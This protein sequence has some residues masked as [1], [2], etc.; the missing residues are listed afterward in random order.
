LSPV[1]FTLVL[2]SALLH[3][4]WSVSIKGSRDPL[5]FNA[6]QEV[7]AIAL[8]LATLPLLSL[9][10]IPGSVWKLLALTGVA[11]ALYFYWMSRAYEHGDLTLVYPIARSTPAFLPLVAVPLF[12]EP[13]SPGGALGI[14]VVVAGMWLVHAGPGLRWRAF[15]SPGAA[16]AYL[17]LAA[18][19]V[20]SLADKG[21]MAELARAPWSSPVPRAAAFYLL[22]SGASALLFIPIVLHRRGLR[23][24]RVAARSDLGSATRASLVSFLGYGLI[25]KALE[26]APASYVV[27]VRQTS[28]I[29]ALLL[30]AALLRERPTRSRIAGASATVLG[31]AL[32]A[33]CGT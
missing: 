20:Y 7:A 31:V 32:I 14:A 13:V 10:E 5:V 2:A 19:V 1:E 12:G 18:T 17:T 3:A 16:Y 33:H 30:G 4:W 11:H 23:C 8:L 21:A 27:A 22:L 25:L 29:F 15:A 26:T 28:V 24:L 9:D 6:L